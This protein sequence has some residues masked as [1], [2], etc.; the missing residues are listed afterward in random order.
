MNVAA[1]AWEARPPGP[2]LALLAA[3]VCGLGMVGWACHPERAAAQEGDPTTT[4]EA[5]TTTTEGVTTTT[6]ADPPTT[7]TEPP[8]PSPTTTIPAP[9]SSWV[10]GDD[11]RAATETL[12][13]VVGG[14]SIL[15]LPIWLGFQWLR[16]V[17]EG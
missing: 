1:W 15:P 12:V 2:R 14:L 6:A 16:Q 17:I 8:P 3:L 11:D 4:T 13:W 9:S 10:H 5:V 7:T